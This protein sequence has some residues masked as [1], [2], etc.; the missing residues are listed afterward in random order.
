[1]TATHGTPR[2]GNQLRVRAD[3]ST[4]ADLLDGPPAEDTPVGRQTRLSQGLCSG[5]CVHGFSVASTSIS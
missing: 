3:Q 5:R 4:T 2:K 1:M